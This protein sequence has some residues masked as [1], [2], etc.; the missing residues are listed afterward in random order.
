MPSTSSLRPY[1]EHAIESAF[2]AW[3]AGYKAPLLVLPTGTGKTV[4]FSAIADRTRNGTVDAG[5]RQALTTPA[6]RAVPRPGKVLILAHREELIDQAVEKL[7]AWTPLRIGVEMAE[8]TVMPM[9]R[10]GLDVVVA[11]VQTLVRRLDR[12]GPEE[13]ELVVIDE[14]HHALATTYRKILDY[15]APALKLGVTATPDRLDGQGLKSVFDCAPFVYELR[16]A[17]EDR[18]LVPLTQKAV[19]VRGLRLDKVR[20]TAGDLNEG[21]LAQALSDAGALHG[22]AKPITEIAERRK[23]LVFATTVEHAHLLAGAI[24]EYVGKDRVESLDGTAAKDRRHGVLQAY[25]RG[26]FQFLVNCL[27]YTEGFDEPSVELVAVGRPTKS[28]ALYAQMIGRGTRLWCPRGCPSFCDHPEAKRSLTVLDFK[29]NAGK[30]VLVNAFD[31]L[32]GAGDERIRERAQ[33]KMNASGMGMLEAL[34]ESSDELAAEE[35]QR[36][37]DDARRHQGDV[38]FHTTTVDPFSLLG[39]T[40]RRGRWGGAPVQPDLLEKL[41]RHRIPTHGLDQGAAMEVWEAVQ[42]RVKDRLSTLRQSMFLAKKGIDGSKLPFDV[43]S[44]IMDRIQRNNWQVPPDVMRQYGGDGNGG[45]QV[46]FLPG[47]QRGA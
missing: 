24:G 42:R 28:R 12:Y 44:Q 45:A 20:T 34:R 16:D 32:D 37:I 38:T 25:R 30:H 35:R 4:I 14:S 10:A 27:L 11:S 15:F 17:I 31:V 22:M 29:G 13:F 8:R 9:E 7:H 26:D 2:S 46:E 39:V 47:G 23:A 5:L 36:A 1:Q 41:K 21:D 43:A 6:D 18:W 40:P 19:Y 33:R 3:K